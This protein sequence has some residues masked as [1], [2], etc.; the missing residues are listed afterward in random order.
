[1]LDLRSTDPA[2]QSADRRVALAVGFGA[3]GCTTFAAVAAGAGGW[4][5]VSGGTLAL[6]GLP[7]LFAFG[8]RRRLLDDAVADVPFA[9]R[10]D[11]AG[12]WATAPVAG[13]LLTLAFAAALGLPAALTLLACLAGAA[14][15]TA[16]LASSE[17]SYE[18]T[19]VLD[20]A[21]LELRFERIADRRA[22][23]AHAPEP[24]GSA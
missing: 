15:Y 6:A 1:M 23:P 16:L 3:V 24:V 18:R 13:A 4:A 5:L 7:W 17:R 19:I 2:R 20:L 21:A 12:V 8:G 10:G 14:G 9:W 11:R 22:L